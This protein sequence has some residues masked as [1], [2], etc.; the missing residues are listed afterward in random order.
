[1]S[2]ERAITWYRIGEFMDTFISKYELVIDCGGQIY[3]YMLS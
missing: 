2:R 1:M 3:G